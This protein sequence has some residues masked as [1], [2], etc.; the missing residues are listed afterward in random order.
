MSDFSTITSGLRRSKKRPHIKLAD[1]VLL[2]RKKFA[3]EE[4]GVSEKT[5]TRMNLPTTYI[6]NL[7][8]VARNASLQ[9]VAEQVRRRNQP[10]KRRGGRAA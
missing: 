1:D 4:L 8:Y 6:G 2:P 9:V 10:P 7:A 5:V 3:E